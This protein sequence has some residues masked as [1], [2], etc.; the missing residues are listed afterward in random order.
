MVMQVR[1]MKDLVNKFILEDQLRIA[2]AN[3]SYNLMYPDAIQKPQSRTQLIHITI[4]LISFNN[5][6]LY[7]IEVLF[8]HLAKD[9][10]QCCSIPH[11]VNHSFQF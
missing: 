10:C 7:L 3:V 1:A 2:L 11:S 8:Y 4:S 6:N 5:H 9:Q